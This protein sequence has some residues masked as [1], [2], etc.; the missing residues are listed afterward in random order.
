MEQAFSALEFR[1]ALGL[2]ATGVAI[3]AASNEH[4]RAGVTVN[5]FASLSL[6]PPLVL[7]SVSRNLRSFRVFEAAPG[8][9]IN[10]LHRTQQEL[11][12][13]FAQP[14]GDKW[15]GVDCARGAHGG[16]LIRGSLVSFDCRAYNRYD[17]GDHLILIGEVTHIHYGQGDAAL[18]YFRR[19]YRHVD[20]A[21]AVPA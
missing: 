8:F 5:S 13:R 14:G 11:S 9:T 19:H 12:A 17:G 20:L 7:C 4:S 10:V 3:L 15:A 1:D 6:E 16:F 21:P 2:F 18:V